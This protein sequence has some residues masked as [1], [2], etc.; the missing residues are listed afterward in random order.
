MLMAMIDG[1]ESGLLTPTPR[2]KN[3]YELESEELAASFPK[4]ILSA[5]AVT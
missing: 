4:A 5:S 1:I 3:I 2:D